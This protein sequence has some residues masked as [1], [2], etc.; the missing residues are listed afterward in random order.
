MSKK[1]DDRTPKQIVMDR[2][3][4]AAADGRTAMAEITARA[5]FVAKNTARLRELRLA[6]EATER[7][8]AANAPPPVEKPKRA[9][10]RSV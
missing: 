1:H 5:A 3:E 4:R 8:E 2:R 7:E 9:P 10:K 6:K